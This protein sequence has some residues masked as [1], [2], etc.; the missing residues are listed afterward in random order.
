[1]TYL[2]YFVIRIS[3]F[4]MHKLYS[5]QKSQFMQ[6]IESLVDAFD[7]KPESDVL[8]IDGSALVNSLSPKTSRTFEEYAVQNVVPIIHTFSSKHTRTDILC[9]MYIGLLVIRL[10][11]DL[12]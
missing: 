11:H 3:F 12:S 5:C 6:V 4:L 7:K 2:N 1:M 9:S 8:I 10:N